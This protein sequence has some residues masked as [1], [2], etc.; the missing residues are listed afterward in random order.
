MRRIFIS[1]ELPEEKREQITE[2]RKT[3]YLKDDL[4]WESVEKLHLTLKYIGDVEENVIE[5]IMEKLDELNDVPA[6]KTRYTRFGNFQRNRIPSILWVGLEA[7]EELKALQKSVEE[8]MGEIGLEMELRPYLPHIT[9]LRIKTPVGPKFIGRF[10][11]CEVPTDEFVCP[12]VVLYQ[13]KLQPG[14]AVYIP[15]KTIQLRPVETGT[16]EVTESDTN[17]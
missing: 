10:I 13:S 16:A 7:T 1:L 6:I 12:K 14:G 8:K 15:L 9:L 11:Q 2:L 17:L 4:Q 5:E 3:R